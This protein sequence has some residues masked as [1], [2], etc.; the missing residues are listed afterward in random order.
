M[1]FT[2]QT[3]EKLDAA[4]RVVDAAGRVLIELHDE[5][6]PED[7]GPEDLSNAVTDLEQALHCAKRALM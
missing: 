4:R 6:F 3:K 2:K 7:D 5:T 1:S